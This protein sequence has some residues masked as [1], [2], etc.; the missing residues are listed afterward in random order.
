MVVD[1]VLVDWWVLVVTVVVVVVIMAMVAMIKRH[2][3]KGAHAFL[4]RKPNPLRLSS[5]LLL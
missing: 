5:Y 1:S 2:V 3:V 4:G